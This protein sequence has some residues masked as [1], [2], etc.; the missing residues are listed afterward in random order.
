MYCCEETLDQ[1]TCKRKKHL[2]GDLLTC[3]RGRVQDYDGEE[4]GGRQGGM[5]LESRW[6]LTSRC[7]GPESE[8]GPGKPRGG[9]Q[10]GH[11]S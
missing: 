4:R 10:W 11:T 5:E 6:E 7:T 3:F 8:A 2:I 9:L 1:A